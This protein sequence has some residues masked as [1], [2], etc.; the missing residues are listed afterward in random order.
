MEF[1]P[2]IDLQQPQLPESRIILGSFPTFPYTLKAGEKSSAAAKP[3]FFY[4]SERNRFWHWYREYVDHRSEKTSI[5]SLLESLNRHGIGITDAIYACERKGQSASDNDL[6]KRV[7]NYHFFRK[8]VKGE[9]IRILCTSKGV[10]NNML[11]TPAFFRE[12][13][14]LQLNHTASVQQQHT[15]MQQL[16]GTDPVNPVVRIL[17]VE[18][19]GTIACAALPSPG[20]PY[21]SLKN[22][23]FTGGDAKMYL[24]HYLK[25]AFQEFLMSDEPNFVP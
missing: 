8:P 15:V 5:D 20:S 13:P 2:R 22:F 10:L 24:D 19:G 21:R 25:W 6:T 7:Y 23:G 16:G 12:H 11:L 3:A 9:T 4:G 18:Q 17:D 14:E 1:H